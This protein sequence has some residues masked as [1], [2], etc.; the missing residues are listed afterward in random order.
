MSLMHNAIACDL[1]AA[2]TM[3]VSYNVGGTKYSGAASSK[4]GFASGAAVPTEV[5]PLTD[6]KLKGQGEG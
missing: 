6:V 1:D 3:E 5:V 4:L 2:M